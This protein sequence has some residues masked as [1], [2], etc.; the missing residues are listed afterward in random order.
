LVSAGLAGRFRQ[1]LEQER[2]C[3]KQK[4]KQIFEMDGNHLTI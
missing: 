4:E 3:E 1:Q 2:D